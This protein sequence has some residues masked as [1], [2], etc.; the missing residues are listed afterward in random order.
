MR[1]CWQSWIRRPWGQVS[2]VDRRVVALGDLPRGGAW[3]Q[4]TVVRQLVLRGLCS[5]VLVLAQCGGVFVVDG[6]R[7]V[8]N[9]WLLG[10]LAGRRG[11]GVGAGSASWVLW[12]HVGAAQWAA[13][14][15]GVRVRGR[16]S[17]GQ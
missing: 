6:A 11:R 13:R 12:L 5:G 9:C 15:G 10:V 4:G 2:E 3:R 7:A 1:E 8:G 17:V 14:A 16:L